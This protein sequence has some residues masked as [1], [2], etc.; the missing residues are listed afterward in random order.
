[1][2]FGVDEFLDQV[3]LRLIA[4]LETLDVVPLESLIQ[5]GIGIGER[6]DAGEQTVLDGVARGMLFTFGGDRAAGLCAIH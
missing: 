5:L 6:E 4:R 1:L 2:P 3:I